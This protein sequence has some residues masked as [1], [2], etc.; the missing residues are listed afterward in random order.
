MY[1]MRID[2]QSPTSTAEEASTATPVNR[3]KSGVPI[4]G[5]TTVADCKLCHDH[6]EFDTVSQQ[7]PY[8]PHCALHGSPSRAQ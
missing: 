6:L 4:T 1:I 3:E 2:T 8:L 7:K 5:S